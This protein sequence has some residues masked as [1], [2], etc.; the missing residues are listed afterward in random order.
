M[1]EHGS[2][3]SRDFERRRIPKSEIVTNSAKL[4]LYGFQQKLEMGIS[5][6]RFVLAIRRNPFVPARSFASCQ[7]PR[8][9]VLFEEQV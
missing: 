7:L 1:R 9:L 2:E 5:S 6:L 4:Q 3:I 8:A